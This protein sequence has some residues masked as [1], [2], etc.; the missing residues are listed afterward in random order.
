MTGV[1]IITIRTRLPS[2]SAARRMAEEESK[3]RIR[4]R[5]AGRNP[6]GADWFDSIASGVREE[7]II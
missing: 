4:A 1:T 3:K 2:G 5:H 6:K 7:W